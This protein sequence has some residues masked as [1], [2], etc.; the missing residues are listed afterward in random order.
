MVIAGADDGHDVCCS[1]CWRLRNRLT[2]T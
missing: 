1:S 2:V